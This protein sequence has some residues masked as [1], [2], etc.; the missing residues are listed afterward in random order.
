MLLTFMLHITTKTIKIS[1]Y[2][3]CLAILFNAMIFVDQALAAKKSD[4]LG[5]E[6]T[7]GGYI[8]DCTNM[9][10]QC[11]DV[12]VFVVTLIGI[13]R[14]LFTIV[15]G[16]FLI[17]FV[18]GGLVWVTSQGNSEKLKKGL[19]IFVAA[20]LGL[21]IVFSAYMLVSYLADALGVANTFKL[22][23]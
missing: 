20:V 2:I 6:G 8:P 22:S 1:K 21:V 7:L 12:S 9:P 18:Y 13:S 10:A 23:T 16:L 5:D 19:D 11:Q 17:M 14:Y 4:M 3:V 15:G